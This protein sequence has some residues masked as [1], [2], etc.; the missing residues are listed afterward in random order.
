MVP[1][2]E[3]DSLNALNPYGQT[4][5][6][7]EEIL[8]D[9]HKSDPTWSIILLR[10][11]NP[12]GAH[13]SGLIGE[14]P[15]GIPNNLVPYVAKVANGELECLS[16][17][18]DDYETPDGTG[19]RDY[20]HVCDLADGHVK[21]LDYVRKHEGLE[22]INLGTGSG[23]SVLE[24]ITSFERV[25]KTKVAY[26]VINRRLGDIATCYA[27]TKKAFHYLGFKADKELD[28]MLEDTW[29]FIK[30]SSHES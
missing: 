14:N 29:R 7:I 25:N 21:A 26:R 3:T 1:F 4:K 9:L 10:Y 12:V 16:V 2:K 18:G 5:K 20:I 24:V 19:V 13:K 27:D 8:V 30:R 22:A 6:M 11:F 23:H 17:F 15:K 28:E